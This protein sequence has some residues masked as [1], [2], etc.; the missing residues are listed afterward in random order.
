MCSAAIQ[1]SDFRSPMNARYN[2][3]LIGCGYVGRRLTRM[4]LEEGQRV[5]VTNRSGT[6]PPDLAGVDTYALDLAAPA[7]I[8]AFAAGF[9]D[10]GVRCIFVL[11]PPG[12]SPEA[13]LIEGPARLLQLPAIAG[14]ERIV[15]AS[16]T[17]VYGDSQGEWVSAETP[18]TVPSGRGLLLR[19]GEQ[20]WGG[21]PGSRVL[22][23]AGLYGPG[24][25]IG[26]ADLRRGDLL[27][28]DPDRW[29][30]LIHV[31][32]AAALLLTLARSEGAAPIEL[33]SD[34]SPVRRRDWYAGLARALNLPEPRF[35]GIV[36]DDGP[37]GAQ[38]SSRRCDPQST[39]QRTG[40]RPRYPDWQS[41]LTASLPGP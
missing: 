38:A 24:R 29:L 34:G 21:H 8:T 26:E 6:S 36:R 31:D 27:A 3:L 18:V 15:V 14:A 37:R 41:G 20:T 28:G 17:A 19:Q 1:N 12:R 39:F 33:G 30:N 2:V 35:D 11:V 32:D 22:R 13:T 7:S 25:L 5:A 9:G 23:L 40:W 16:S 10:R 4:L